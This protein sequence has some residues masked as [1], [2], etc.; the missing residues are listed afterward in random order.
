[1]EFKNVGNKSCRFILKKKTKFLFT[2]GIS[3]SATILELFFIESEFHQTS[4]CT[5]TFR[6]TPTLAMNTHKNIRE[7]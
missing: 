4:C 5:T 6:N 7:I 2:V 3:G 1:M